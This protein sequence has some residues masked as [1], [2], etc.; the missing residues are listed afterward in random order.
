MQT[1]LLSGVSG[2]LGSNLAETLHKNYK[3][4]GLKR[5]TSNCHR[6]QNLTIKTYNVDKIK[7]DSIFD[8]HKID[9]IIHTATCYG[10]R[11]EPL[12]HL[13]E[14]NLVFSLKLLELARKF[15]IK[16]FI[17]ADTLQ[18]DTLSN[19]TISKRT[20]RDYLHNFSDINL[21][22]CRIEHIYGNDKDNSKFSTYLLDA[23]SDDVPYIPLTSGRQRRDFIYI[24]DVI[25]AFELILRS[26]MERRN[27]RS[28]DI[29]SGEFVSVRSFAECLLSEFRRHR[30]CKTRL[31]FGAI[32]YTN[33]GEIKEN[34]APLRALG[35]M[36]KYSYQNGIRALVEAYLQNHGAKVCNA[37][38]SA[39]KNRTAKVYNATAPNAKNRKWGG[40]ESSNTLQPRHYERS[41]VIH[42]NTESSDKKDLLYGLP[43]LE[44]IAESRND[45][46]TLIVF[47][48]ERSNQSKPRH[49]YRLCEALQKAEA[50]HR[51]SI[52]LRITKSQKKS[53]E[54]LESNRILDC[55][56]VVPTSRNDGIS[57]DC[58]E[59]KCD[60]YNKRKAILYKNA[61][62]SHIAE[63]RKNK[64]NS[65]STTI[66]T[67]KLHKSPTR[68]AVA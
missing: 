57:V 65:D 61:D 41:E 47:A 19:Y 49:F 5:S 21:I 31:D 43:R 1:I 12:S 26:A 58:H 37:E 33:L 48:I 25:R 68:K 11:G 4:I 64:T 56:E 55:H 6:L 62:S 14:T 7:L 13:V 32:P 17:N 60:S 67:L 44:A 36:A 27:E 8:K 66:F 15:S 53:A 16:A 42:K 35:F 51:E 10:R 52:F 28:Y 30:E 38:N 34:L 3:I 63:S 54:S 9:I 40:A 23:F 29:G 18:I 24:D 50:I 39:V 59:Y 2:F 45:D 22:N 20:L 46:S